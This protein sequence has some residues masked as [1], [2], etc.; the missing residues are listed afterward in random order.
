MGS[1]NPDFKRKGVILRKGDEAQARTKKGECGTVGRLKLTELVKTLT[2]QPFEGIKCN[3]TLMVYGATS[4]NFS[5]YRTLFH[6][7][8]TTEV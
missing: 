2:G 4:M 8:L 5:C 1:S 6:L 7:S 3:R